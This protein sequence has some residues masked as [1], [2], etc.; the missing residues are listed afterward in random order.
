MLIIVIQLMSTCKKFSILATIVV[1]LP[2]DFAILIQLQIIQ[3][4]TLSIRALK[5]GKVS[6]K[7]HQLFL[8]MS[9]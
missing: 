5:P 9:T 2:I 8:H 4:G 3:N 7:L 6:D 1:S